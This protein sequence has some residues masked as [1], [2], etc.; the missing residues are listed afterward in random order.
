MILLML[1]KVFSN[2]F[3]S[4]QTNCKH[5]FFKVLNIKNEILTIIYLATHPQLFQPAEL[6]EHFPY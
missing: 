1:I 2:L 4:P 6:F 5:I 3:P